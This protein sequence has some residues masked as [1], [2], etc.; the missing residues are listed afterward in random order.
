MAEAVKIRAE[1]RD[2]GKNKG[3]GTRVARRIRKQGRIPAIVYG[4]KQ[5]PQPIS[6]ARD[7]IWQM[8][9]TSTHL[10]E[11]Q[12]DGG[13]ETVLVKD[14][15]WDHLGKEVLHVDFARVSADEDVDAVVRLDLKGEAPG[16][17][18]GGVIEHLIHSIHVVCRA[19]AIPDSIKIDV[20]NLQLNKAIHLRELTLPEGVKAKG[21]PE[22][23]IVHVTSRVTQAEPTAPA[24]EGEAA[25]AGVQPEVI[26]PERKEK[27]E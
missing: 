3:T 27:E 24:V 6:I 15:Q 4:H 20:S 11:L 8:L 13:G 17:A 21:D 5:A 19:S 16:V 10:A 7:S 22:A 26:K 12:W 9:K 23:L 18:A 14:I 25:A 1:L 2:A